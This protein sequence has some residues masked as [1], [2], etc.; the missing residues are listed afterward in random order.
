VEP[1]VPGTTADAQPYPKPPPGT[2]NRDITGTRS[3]DHRSE[4]ARLVGASIQLIQVV[5]DTNLRVLS[6]L[7]MLPH[8]LLSRPQRQSGVCHAKFKLDRENPTDSIRGVIANLH[9]LH[10]DAGCDD[11]LALDQCP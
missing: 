5:L 7:I 3:A 1:G 6:R 10:L 4:T 11:F 9:S 2:G 8:K